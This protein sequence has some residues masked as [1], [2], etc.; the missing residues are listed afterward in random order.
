M[1]FARC[2][3]L[4]CS[5]R[6]NA[7]RH[8]PGPAPSPRLHLINSIANTF[9]KIKRMRE[10]GGRTMSFRESY[11]A[12]CVSR[13][14]YGV[15]PARF[16]PFFFR[17]RLFALSA[18]RAFS[19][20]FSL[21]PLP[22]VNRCIRR[23]PISCPLRLPYP[24]P[25]RAFNSTTSLILLYPFRLTLPPLARLAPKCILRALVA[26]MHTAGFSARSLSSRFIGHKFLF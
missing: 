11:E 14:L 18:S 23:V 6:S 19:R 13:P 10:P 17:F 5:G 15:H 1:H 21:S 12:R 8:L 2:V 7:H 3:S 24:L 16:L 9:E 20:S 25:H 22:R 4:A 26:S